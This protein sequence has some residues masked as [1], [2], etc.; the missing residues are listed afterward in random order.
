MRGEDDAES[1][2]Q[3]SL[4]VMVAL[5][6]AGCGAV[7]LRCNDDCGPGHHQYESARYLKRVPAL[8][9]KQRH[10][11]AGGEPRRCRISAPAGMVESA[12]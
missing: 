7:A 2:S 9:R 6:Y 4:E 10:S 1:R 5:I 12:P 11:G 3:Q 8:R